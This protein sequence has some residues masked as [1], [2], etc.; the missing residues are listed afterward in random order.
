ML[1]SKLKLLQSFKI[2]DHLTVTFVNG[3]KFNGILLTVSDKY[4]EI[5]SA[6]NE[7]RQYIPWTD[8]LTLDF[9]DKTSTY[10]SSDSY[11]WWNTKRINAS[12]QPLSL[13]TCFRNTFDQI[14]SNVSNS[15]LSA[16]FES[17]NGRTLLFIENREKLEFLNIIEPV[18]LQIHTSKE[19]RTAARAFLYLAAKDYAGGMQELVQEMSINNTDDLLLVMA[20]FYHDMAD[21]AAAFYWLGFYFDKLSH[22]QKQ[23]GLW[24]NFC[25]RQ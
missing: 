18:L 10:N 8:I 24:W 16:I 15:I 22:C 4:I 14:A 2:Y 23:D 25:F 1:V 6:T 21:G 3:E 7:T 19:E 12:N 13:A 5:Q 20:C 11:K 17:R 9:A